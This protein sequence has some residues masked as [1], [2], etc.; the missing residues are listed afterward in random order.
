MAFSAFL[1]KPIVKNEITVPAF[2][3]EFT[4]AEKDLRS[5]GL[6]PKFYKWCMD[7]VVR[8][9]GKVYF[10]GST[11]HRGWLKYGF[12]MHKRMTFY[13]VYY[14]R[15]ETSTGRKMF[16]NRALLQTF[17][18]AWSFL[19]AWRHLIPKKRVTVAGAIGFDQFM[20]YYGRSKRFAKPYFDSSMFSWRLI[21]NY[22]DQ[23]EFLMG[24][25][26]LLIGLKDGNR[27][28]IID[29]YCSSILMYISLIDCAC[30]RYSQVSF[31]GNIW[32][33]WKKP[34]FWCNLMLGFVTYIG[35]GSYV[36]K[37]DLAPEVS[38][39]DLSLYEI[40]DFGSILDC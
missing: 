27:L 17:G 3:S 36:E 23:H 6:F 26:G 28:R 20:A 33:E 15:H 25:D 10:W 2:R 8:K 4:I 40:W 37:N 1:Y 12:T 21:E 16:F 30:T 13:Q 32:T 14:G 9:N 11:R 29:I 5:T 22:W 39:K 18:Y 34:W 7:E 24:E 35:G 31:R 19:G 38:W